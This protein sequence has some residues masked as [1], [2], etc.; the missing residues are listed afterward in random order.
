MDLIDYN[1]IETVEDSILRSKSNSSR[2]WIWNLVGLVVIIVMLLA[3]YLTREPEPES[4]A[5]KTQR[6]INDSIKPSPTFS[7]F[8]F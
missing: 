2:S 8:L 5:E 4:G 6:M 7:T 3:L 1:V